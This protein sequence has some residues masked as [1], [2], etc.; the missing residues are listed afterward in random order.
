MVVSNCPSGAADPP[1]ELLQ[2]MCSYLRPVHLGEPTEWGKLHENQAKG[3]ADLCSLS[4][5]CKGLHDIV[6]PIL[7]RSFSDEGTDSA[8]RQIQFLYALNSR[9]DLAQHVRVLTFSSSSMKIKPTEAEH[10][11]LIQNTTR[12]GIKTPP[13]DWHEQGTDLYHPI[14]AELILSLT[15]NLEALQVSL[16]AHTHLPVVERL[17]RDPFLPLTVV[18]PE[19]SSEQN[20]VFHGAVFALCAAAPNPHSLSIIPLA[21][22]GGGFGL[23]RPRARPRRRRRQRHCRQ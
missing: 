12:L 1:V 16:Y 9:P 19:G 7:F 18:H 11:V 13:A 21:H 5:T 23:R 14:N 2:D 17:S 20:A 4:R 6:Q 15:Q 10:T 22:P 8:R 3:R